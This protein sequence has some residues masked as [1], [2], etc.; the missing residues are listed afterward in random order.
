MKTKITKESLQQLFAKRNL[1]TSQEL[2]NYFDCTYQCLWSNLRQLNYLSSYTH[3]SKYYTLSTIAEFDKNGI[4]FC[5]DPI[6]GDVGFT[7][8]V[9]AKSLIIS[10]INSST[11]GMTEDEIS[12]IVN[13]R[14]LNQL[15]ILSLNAAIKKEKLGRKYRYFSTDDQVF[16]KQHAHF[17]SEQSSVKT[18]AIP[19]NQQR[20][21]G[22]EGQKAY[23][24]KLKRLSS[25]RDAWNQRSNEKQQRI[26]ALLLR[27]RD[28]ERSRDKWK[29]EAMHYKLKTS[30][31]RSE[32]ATIK[33]TPDHK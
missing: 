15:N 20:V 3:N 22:I 31:L 13:I 25:S 18:G 17:H 24:E 26:R 5:S 2:M 10:L 11:S 21:P 29:Q 7:K 32:I 6:I 19:G 1:W 16:E 28:L 9:T 33:K 12:A 30:A 14:V 8:H 27:V 23:L 4:W